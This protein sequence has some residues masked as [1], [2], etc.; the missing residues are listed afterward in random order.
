MASPTE[1]LTDTCVAIHTADTGLLG[2]E[3]FQKHLDTLWRRLKRLT[4]DNH[5]ELAD[6]IQLALNEVTPHLQA[7]PAG[8]DT[9]DFARWCTDTEAAQAALNALPLPEGFLEMTRTAKGSQPQWT[10]R[11]KEDDATVA[12]LFVLVRAIVGWMG[13]KRLQD[14]GVLTPAINRAALIQQAKVGQGG[15]YGFGEADSMGDLSHSVV[16]VVVATWLLRHQGG[17]FAGAALARFGPG[18]RLVEVNGTL[19]P[20][21]LEQT[22]DGQMV[23][24]P[25]RGTTALPIVSA[26]QQ[27]LAMSAVDDDGQIQIPGLTPAQLAQLRAAISTAQLRRWLRTYGLG[28]PRAV[29]YLDALGGPA[30]PIEHKPR[31][32]RPKADQSSAGE[33]APAAPSV[34]AMSVDGVDL[35]ALSDPSPVESSSED[36]SEDSAHDQVGRGRLLNEPFD[37]PVD[38]NGPLTPGTPEGL[39]AL[40]ENEAAVPTE[41][42]LG[43]VLRNGGGGGAQVG[44]E[45]VVPNEPVVT[46]KTSSVRPVIAKPMRTKKLPLPPRELSTRTLRA[47]PRYL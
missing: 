9:S 17:E 7:L 46:A 29:Q 35:D 6:R 47:P 22:P 11:K 31:V 34:L 21:R 30:D 32:S 45:A 33:G 38:D 26:H 42:M 40:V 37:M 16:L 18:L 23:L 14:C 28:N 27:H 36:S 1:T 43:A 5:S 15:N 20:C 44:G 19:R 41:V 10:F 2:N 24:A 39:V 25:V 3:E 13:G 4:K 12:L 8:T